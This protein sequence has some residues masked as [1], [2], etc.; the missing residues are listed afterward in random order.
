MSAVEYTYLSRS[1]HLE[2]VAGDDNVEICR[3]EGKLGVEIALGL[4]YPQVEELGGVDEIVL[5]AKAEILALGVTRVDSVN[6][7]VGEDIVIFYPIFEAVAKLPK[8]SVLE[9]RPP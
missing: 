7:G 8:I 1:V 4:Y 3:R 9:C 6:Q 5:V 2:L